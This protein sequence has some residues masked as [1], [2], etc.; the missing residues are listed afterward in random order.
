MR[1]C[2]T[3]PPLGR[4]AGLHDS[5]STTTVTSNQ[6]YNT[7]LQITGHVARQK[8][9]RQR[10]LRAVDE[11]DRRSLGFPQLHSM[12]RCPSY[13]RFGKLFPTSQLDSGGG[14]GGFRRVRGDG[15]AFF[16]LKVGTDLVLLRDRGVSMPA[17]IMTTRLL[18][19]GV[20]GAN[21]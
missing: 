8:D 10:Y 11:Y 1:H 21:V 14:R 16:P 18:E 20:W 13:Q 9:R 5:I 2:L 4:R 7:S 6:V 12:P 15:W 3:P 19:Q 17:V